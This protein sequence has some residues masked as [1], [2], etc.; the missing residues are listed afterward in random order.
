MPAYTALE[1]E[2]NYLNTPL[3]PLGSQ[4]IAGITPAQRQSWAPHGTKAWYIGPALD[5]YRCVRVYIPKTKGTEIE[6]MFRWS[7]S[8]IFTLP[9]ITNEE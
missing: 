4:V 2:F 6:D 7:D 3:A 1:G 5:H 8:N 9:K